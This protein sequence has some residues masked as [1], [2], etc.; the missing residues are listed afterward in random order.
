M[1]RIEYRQD[2]AL[3]RPCREGPAERQFT[4]QGQLLTEAYFEHGELHNEHGPALR[5]FA[6]GKLQ[7]ET[8]YRR[9]KKHADNGP[10][11]S[12]HANKRQGE[13]HSYFRQG[14][15]HRDPSDGPAL[16]EWNLEGAIIQ[17]VYWVNGR[18][19]KNPP[20]TKGLRRPR[21]RP[22]EP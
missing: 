15:R 4:R 20:A 2:G 7:S 10:A 18:R 14:R 1:D 17:S 9:G 13:I 19:L 8:Y 22:P 3:H 16:I 11:V 21:R 6:D 12:G 5:L